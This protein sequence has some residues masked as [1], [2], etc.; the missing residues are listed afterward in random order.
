MIMDQ[1]EEKRTAAVKETVAEKFERLDAGGRAHV[2]GYLMGKEDERKNA[3][4]PLAVWKA[5]AAQG[6]RGRGRFT[7]NIIPKYPAKVNENKGD[8]A[9]MAAL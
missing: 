4:A 3:P 6:V 1:V 9:P 5:K 8:S 2:M 7:G